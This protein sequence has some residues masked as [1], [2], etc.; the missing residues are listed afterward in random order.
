MEDKTEK[1]E[2]PDDDWVV[3]L[4]DEEMRAFE[5][6]YFKMWLARQELQKV[7]EGMKRVEF[8]PARE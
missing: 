3:Y 4:P 5:R 2:L 8:P 1:T 7:A 6:A